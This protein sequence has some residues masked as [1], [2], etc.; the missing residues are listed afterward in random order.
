MEIKLAMAGTAEEWEA[1][2]YR[3]AELHKETSSHHAQATHERDQARL[4]LAERDATITELRAQLTKYEQDDR[5]IIEF[6]EDGWTLMHPLACRPNLF[7]CPVNRI[8]G[9]QLSEPPDLLGR[10]ECELIDIAG[11]SW[12]A[13]GAKCS[14]DGSDD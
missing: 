1:A 5:H 2:Y 11:Q 13:I 3:L 6:R 14:G 9:R 8:A 4:A 12:L 10:F 7:D